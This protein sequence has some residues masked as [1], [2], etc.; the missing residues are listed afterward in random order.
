MIFH[1]CFLFEKKSTVFF[2]KKRAEAYHITSGN[3]FP[4]YKK[5]GMKK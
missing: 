3:K 5:E 4:Q 1:L 2:S